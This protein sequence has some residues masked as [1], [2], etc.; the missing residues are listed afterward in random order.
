MTRKKIYEI[1]GFER[2]K[3]ENSKFSTK[4]QVKKIDAK[5]WHN[6]MKQTEVKALT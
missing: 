6:G 3:N 2:K 5:F 4:K 1:A